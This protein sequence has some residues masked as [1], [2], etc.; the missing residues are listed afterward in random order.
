MTFFKK[1]FKIYLM[2][3]GNSKTLSELFD[4]ID[5]NPDLTL[6]QAKKITNILIKNYPND[7][8][9]AFGLKYYRNSIWTKAFSENKQFMQKLEDLK[10]IELS[11]YKDS[12]ESLPNTNVSYQM[13]E[14][15]TNIILDCDYSNDEF[16]KFAK[17]HYRIEPWTTVFLNNE[18]FIQKIKYLKSLE[19]SC[20]IIATCNLN[21]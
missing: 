2:K 13:A 18:R 7:K 14:D 21:A 16:L 3:E 19:L 11:A 6:N 9:I 5:S 15:L 1:R 8:I 4:Q 12:I 17:N 10:K 20:N